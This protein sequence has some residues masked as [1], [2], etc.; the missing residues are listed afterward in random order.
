LSFLV[1][2]LGLPFILPFQLKCIDQ[3]RHRLQRLPKWPPE[4][5]HPCRD[6]NIFNLEQHPQVQTNQQAQHQPATR[7]QRIKEEAGQETRGSLGSCRG[8]RD[9]CKT[10]GSM[11]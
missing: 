4:T 7:S 8:G 5:W 10:F 11:V 9:C 1:P 6:F 2:S 3:P